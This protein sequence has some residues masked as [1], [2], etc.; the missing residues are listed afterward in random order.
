MRDVLRLGAIALSLFG[1]APAEE[2]I[3]WEATAASPAQ[4]RDLER[5][6]SQW[7]AI[8]TRQQHIA[9][10]GSPGTHRVLFVS[11]SEIPADSEATGALY[12]PA[13]KTAYVSTGLEERRFLALLHEQGHALGLTHVSAGVMHKK[14]SSS[15]DFTQDDVEECRRVG[16]CD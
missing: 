9:M 10:P 16:I 1:C 8:A 7:N 11:R 5:S 13:T 4:L 3:V 2:D 15:T 14:G 12:D 6:C